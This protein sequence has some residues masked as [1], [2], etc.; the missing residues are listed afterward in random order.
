[1]ATL[2][3]RYH[4]DPEFHMLVDT[5]VHQ[6]STCRFTPSEIRE[7]GILAS[8]IYE[9]H[10]IRNLS[11]VEKDVEYHLRSLRKRLDEDKRT[12]GR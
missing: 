10:N 9:E 12:D 3:E 5:L 1:V 4:N 7:A 2:R 8:I 11:F 6:I